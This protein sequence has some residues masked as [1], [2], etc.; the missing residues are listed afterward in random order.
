[1][2][3]YQLHLLLFSGHWLRKHLP[4]YYRNPV[5]ITLLPVA[6][7]LSRWKEFCTDIYFIHKISSYRNV[8]YFNSSMSSSL[9]IVVLAWIA[10]T[11][12]SDNESKLGVFYIILGSIY[13]VIAMIEVSISRIFWHSIIMVYPGFW[14]LRCRNSKFLFPPQHHIADQMLQRRVAAVR[15]FA[16]LSILVTLLALV[17]YIIQTVVHYT[18]KVCTLGI[19]LL[20][21][22]IPFRMISSIFVPI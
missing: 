1:M 9:C 18:F 17:G 7:V 2:I 15:S 8:P 21:L 11:F 3:F 12:V 22:L 16:Y 14:R 19:M 6:Y 20:S 13:M 4:F 5:L 10:Y